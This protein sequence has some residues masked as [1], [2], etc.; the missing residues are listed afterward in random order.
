MLVACPPVMAAVL[1]RGEPLALAW[2][3]NTLQ[4]LAGMALGAGALRR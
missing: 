3:V 2:G 1:A 4:S